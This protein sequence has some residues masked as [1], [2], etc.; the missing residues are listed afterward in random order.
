MSSRNNNVNYSMPIKQA[1]L[2]HIKESREHPKY[3]IIYEYLDDYSYSD[4]KYSLIHLKKNKKGK[5]EF[6]VSMENGPDS[7]DILNKLVQWRISGESEERGHKGGG[8]KRFIYGHEASRVIICSRLNDDDFLKLELSPNQIF[9]LSKS[10]DISEGDFQ[11]QVDRDG[12]RWSHIYDFDEDGGW[13][14]DYINN[15]ESD[16]NKKVNYVMRF[17]FEDVPA[18]YSDEF[19]WN[20]FI[21]R[22]AMKNYDIDIFYKNELIGDNSFTKIKNI[23]MLGFSNIGNN[24]E[25]TYGDNETGVKEFLLYTDNR[26]NPYIK[27]KNKYY[28]QKNN[29]VNIFH[30]LQPH[31]KIKTFIINKEH[32][33]K[34]LKKINNINRDNTKYTNEHFYGIYIKIN[35]KQTNYLPIS[36]LIVPS[37]NLGKYL[38][39]S[40]FRIVVEPVCD[41]I[42]LEKFIITDTIKAKTRFKDT[43]K[44]KN[45]FSTIK[46]HCLDRGNDIP[47]VPPPPPNPTYG[48]CY[49]IYLGYYVYKFGYVQDYTKVKSRISSHKNN[50]K[51]IKDFLTEEE[52]DGE[53]IDDELDE[54]KVLF[55][56][57]PVERYRGCEE[58][59]SSLLQNDEM[60]EMYGS[61]NSN[62]PREYFK[63]YD[64]D[65]IIRNILPE[66]C[67]LQQDY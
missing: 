54:F 37:K 35:G 26:G 17:T 36:D 11:K 41:N 28:N 24:V 46:S 38:R 21:S 4:S 15:I 44:A 33:D 56:T 27:Y 23:D 57:C 52:L 20:E 53:N 10:D 5:T 13:F 50:I 19:L 55:L 65:H 22:I 42:L 47:P 7:N 63:C 9:E 32:F 3:E 61:L 12:I 43:S 60:I 48:M 39:N 29:E 67:S 16:F 25:N 51:I 58:A 64:N 34:N 18:E 66:I 8:N 62:I 45:I 40:Y 31:S 30:H 14:K 49:L 59:I 1:Y 2:S 6:Y